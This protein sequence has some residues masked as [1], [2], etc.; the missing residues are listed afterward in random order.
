MYEIVNYYANMCEATGGKAQKDKLMMHR[1]KWKG[2][3][4]FE[5]PINIT[6]NK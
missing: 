2:D 4:I 5:V 1:C 6:I 3:N